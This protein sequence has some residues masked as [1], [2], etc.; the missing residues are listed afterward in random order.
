VVE[1]NYKREV[2]F[3]VKISDLINN[4]F[5]RNEGF[6][7]SY[8]LVGVEKVSRVNVIGIITEKKS[9]ER[10]ISL[11]ID[12]SYGTITS[13]FFDNIEYI[14]DVF[15][16][17]DVVIVVGRVNDFNGIKINGEVIRKID[18]GWIDVRK[19]EFEQYI[20]NYVVE[21]K[22]VQVNE[23]QTKIEQYLFS[24]EIDL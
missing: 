2:A 3:K 17:G 23:K 4:T 15:S 19:K 20:K 22:D 13:T 8:V 5:I 1:K 11:V 14:N 16:V 9:S 10:I 24:D 6:E 7:P 12:D 18:R 21:N